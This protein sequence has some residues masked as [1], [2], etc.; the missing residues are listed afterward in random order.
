[1]WVQ[2]STSACKRLCNTSQ[3][4]HVA[5]TSFIATDAHTSIDTWP[6]LC[7]KVLRQPWEAALVLFL[8]LTLLLLPLL[9]LFR[10]FFISEI[11]LR[12][13]GPGAASWGPP[14]PRPPYPRFG[15]TAALH[16]CGTLAA[17]IPLLHGGHPT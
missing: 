13:K 3:C 16:A 6:H 15:S 11:F 7:I 12:D 5:M 17:P 9:L 2:Q 1:M 8:M 10:C 4:L 14:V